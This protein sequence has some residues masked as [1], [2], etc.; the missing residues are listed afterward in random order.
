VTITLTD[1]QL[2]LV[3][4]EMSHGAGL[5]RSLSGVSDLEQLRRLVSPLMRDESYNRSTF[6]ALMVLAAFP[7]DG[8]ERGLRDVAVDVDVSPSI[9][10]HYIRTLLAAD[11]LEQDPDSRRYRR[12]LPGMGAVLR[13][14]DTNAS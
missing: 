1:E 7:T 12:A 6:R 14:G 10:H 11:V 9:A 2:A 4:R 13:L 8:S 5:A 3:A